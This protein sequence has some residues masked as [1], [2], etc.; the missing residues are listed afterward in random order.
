MSSR[1]VAVTGATGYIGRPLLA[2]LAGEPGIRVRGLSRRPL[3]A[4][5]GAWVV[6]QGDLRDPRA[7]RRLLRP[8]CDVVHLAHLWRESFEENL[9]A[10]RTVL[11]ACRELDVRRLVHLSTVAVFG[12]SPGDRLDEASACRP[13]VPY[14]R[15]KLAIESLL[16]E[17]CAVPYVVLRPTTLFSDSGPPLEPLATSL[18]SGRRM[19]AYLR[20]SAFSSRRMNLVHADAV[21]AAIAFMLAVEP[22]PAGG[23]FIVSQDEDPA[24]NFRDVERCLMS[25]LAVRDYALPPVPVPAWLLSLALRVRGHNNVE[26]RRVF[27]SGRIRSLGFEPPLDFA[28]A[29]ATCTQRIASQ[30]MS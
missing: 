10:V 11:A 21:A 27:D 29:L 8:G 17:E 3:E 19:L 13:V 18:R 20:S 25:A 23:T 2:R 22:F 28:R 16:R 9:Q 26:P 24:N 4:T 12:R 6:V 1:T 7:V 30:C 5:S 15:L 14:G